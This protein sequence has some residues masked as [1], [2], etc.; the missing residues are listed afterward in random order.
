MRLLLLALTILSTIA[1]QAQAY[2]SSIT[3]GKK[4]Q[5]TITNYDIF[6]HSG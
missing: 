2:E 3:Y 4:K 6:K 5:K 1:V